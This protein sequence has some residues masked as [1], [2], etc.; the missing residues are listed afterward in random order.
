MCVT[1]VEEVS[2]DEMTI[3][4]CLKPFTP[5]YLITSHICFMCNAKVIFPWKKFSFFFNIASSAFGFRCRHQQVHGCLFVSVA[6][7]LDHH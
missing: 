3:A 5:M 6:A 7:C 2:V 4:V 1:L